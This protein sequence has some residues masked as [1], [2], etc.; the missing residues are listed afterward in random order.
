VRDA[1]PAGRSH[2]EQINGQRRS[3]AAQDKY[4]PGGRGARAAFPAQAKDAVWAQG[5]AVR[6]L[7]AAGQIRFWAE[8]SELE[9]FFFSIFRSILNMN[10]FRIQ[11]SVN[12]CTNMYYL[13]SKKL[14][15][16]VHEYL[17]FHVFPL[18]RI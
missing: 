2:L 7:G 5:R 10:F 12:K 9:C 17:D 13:K 11:I 3:A 4:G 1:R 6:R 18:R 15:K 14:Q 8:Y 16:Y